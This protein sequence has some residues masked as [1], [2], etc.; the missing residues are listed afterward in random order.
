MIPWLDVRSDRAAF[1]DPRLALKE[2]NG[3][4]A[5]GGDLRPDRL[6]AAYERGIFPWYESGQPILWWSPD[7]RAVLYPDELHVSRSLRK[8]IRRGAFQV[9]RD[10]AFGQIISACANRG[11]T[12]G[13][14]IT[15]EMADAYGRLFALQAAHS[16]EIWNGDRLVGGIYGVTIGRVFFGESMFSRMADASKAALLHL[17]AFLKVHRYGLIDC[18]IASPHLASLGSREIPRT[19]FL[20]TLERLCC[21]APDPGQ[22]PLAPETL[23]LVE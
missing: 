9:S 21:L 18:Q 5:A 13:T 15:N 2:P 20:E 14:W 17:V 16:V 11:P 22:W 12:T 19:E 7:P 6:L 8:T 10:Q 23:R 3:L 1:P 4:L